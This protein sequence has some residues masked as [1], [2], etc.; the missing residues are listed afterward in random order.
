MGGDNDKF[1]IRVYFNFCCF[2]V[3]RDCCVWVV[4]R[5][6]KEVGE[7]RGGVVFVGN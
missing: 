5:N 3:S 2:G 7:F 1:L 6:V 4:R